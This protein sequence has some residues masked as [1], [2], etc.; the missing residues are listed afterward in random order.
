MTSCDAFEAAGVVEFATPV[1]F[2]E[3]GYVAG[4]LAKALVGA[5]V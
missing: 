4:K 2:G 5:S 1:A 3:V